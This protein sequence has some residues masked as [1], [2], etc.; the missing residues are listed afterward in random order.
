MT[1]VPFFKEKFE[2]LKKIH[3][4]NKLLVCIDGLSGAG[5]SDAAYFLQQELEKLGVKLP[6]MEAGKVMRAVA[7]K[8]GYTMNEFAEIRNKNKKLA[9]KFDIELDHLLLEHGI[10]NGEIIVARMSGSVLG[11]EADVRIFI[12]ADPQKIA[13]RIVK[14]K[15]RDEYKQPVEEIKKAIQNR[16]EHDIKTYEYL[17]NIDYM[18]LKTGKGS[19]VI[20]N[21][22]TLEDLR[23][24]MKKIAQDLVK[25]Q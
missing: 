2:E 16:T 20:H 3:Q 11:D 1:H 4:R 5:K 22:G 7:K 17:Y 18:K 24:H 19:I 25:N 23:N 6:I 8:H 15:N 14:G 10:K 12:T 9:E 21:D 13:E